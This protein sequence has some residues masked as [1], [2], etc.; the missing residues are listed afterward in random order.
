MKKNAANPRYTVIIPTKDRCEYLFHT[1][2]TCS[3]QDYDNF[4]VIVSDDGSK[5][6]TRGVVEEASR[7]DSR[8]K[9]IKPENGSGMLYNFEYALD[10]VKD[11][12][13]TALGGDDG[14]IPNSISDID[15]IF[16][17]Y[18]YDV[19]TWP[20]PIYSYP[21]EYDKS[22]RLVIK[23]K[24]GRPL[25]GQ[26]ILKSTDIINKQIQNLEYVGDSEL[27]MFYVKSMVSTDVVKKVKSIT[28]NNVFYA[29]SVPDGYSGI[30][31]AGVIDEY[32]FSGKPFSIFG[33][34]HKSTG[35]AYLDSTK[36]SLEIA[37]NFF[38]SVS[39]V[40]LH[41]KLGSAPYSPLIA[42]M[43]ADF[44]FTA[45]DLNGWKG[46]ISKLDIKNIIEKSLKE[47]KNGNW[48]KDNVSRELAII[49]RIAEQYS[50][51]DYFH[52]Q[53]NSLKRNTKKEIRG[54]AISSKQ[55]YIDASDYG[56]ENILD[57]AYFFFFI[58]N[59]GENVSLKSLLKGVTNSISHKISTK[60]N[61]GGF[62]PE[63]E[64][65]NLG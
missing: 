28:P 15:T 6:D 43:T 16:K 57:A 65:P 49:K 38:N 31:I 10:Q 26:K 7:K 32:I 42:I 34:S 41:K 63:S 4:E 14:L 22:G 17:Q 13:V 21:S 37:N 48:A 61:A 1:L 33:S 27:P 19:L 3:E 30:A 60:K 12:Y 9:Y 20:T 36:K 5:D 59:A 58:H 23:A 46:D 53:V 29:C 47:L 18:P 39:K 52:N 50:L 56:I 11:G 45:D 8:I 25:N 64:W 54:N 51:E 44:L 35:N 55:I 2:K 40:P 24:F 62:P